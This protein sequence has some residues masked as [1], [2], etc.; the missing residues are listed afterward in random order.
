MKGRS[1]RVDLGQVCCG[2]FVGSP[3]R[4]CSSLLY[5]E[6]STCYGHHKCLHRE[7]EEGGGKLRGMS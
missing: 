4:D 3:V 2:V 7:F 1:S 5:E 6:G